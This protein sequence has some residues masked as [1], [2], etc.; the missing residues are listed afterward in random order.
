MVERYGAKSAGVYASYRPPLHHPIV[1]EA[2]GARHFERALDLGCGVG[3]S[4]KALLDHCD[5]VLGIDPSP[6]MI[7]HAMPHARIAYH[8]ADVTTLPA[9]DQNFDLV[10]VAGALPYID[11]TGFHAQLQRLCQ[12]YAKVLIYDF[13]L[14]M[15]PIIEALQLP[16]TQSSSSYAHGLNLSHIDGFSTVGLGTARKSF[17]AKPEEVAC[18]LLANAD[19]FEQLAVCF[20]ASDPVRSLEAL[21]AKKDHSWEIAADTWYALH[22][23]QYGLN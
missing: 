10:S 7:A 21:I 18:I 19:R 17:V 14:D 1:L 23:L 6:G 13:K 4:A 20:D 8:V 11:L 9:G 22:E 2:L 16:V 5:F 12:Q 3:H 15:S